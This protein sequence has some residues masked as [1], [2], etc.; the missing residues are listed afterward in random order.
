[1]LRV[2]IFVSIAA[3]FTCYSL[4]AVSADGP[5]RIIYANDMGADIDDAFALVF[6]LNSPELQI[7]CIINSFGR[8]PTKGKITAR[9]LEVAGRQDI[10]N[11]IGRVTEDRPQRFY[12]GMFRWVEGYEYT[13]PPVTDG[14]RA[15]ARRI[16]N[17]PG[18]VTVLSVGPLTDIA[19]LL[20][21]E[22]RVKDK[23]DEIIMMGGTID[24]GYPDRIE[25]NVGCDPNATQIVFASGLPIVMLG[26]DVTHM[27]QPDK[28]DMER[29]AA[30]DKPLARAVH[31]LF[32]AWGRHTPT[33][34]D[35]VAIAVAIER[36]IVTFEPMRI[37]VTDEGYTRKVEG[38]PNA[39]VGVDVDKDRFFKLF[40]E[41]VMK[42]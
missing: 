30:T 15:L 14:W 36:N 33:M 1:M 2:L 20:Q 6:A 35:A 25:H 26:F 41:R 17:A 40:W 16:L 42:N 27:M 38:E 13:K 12:G 32:L 5:R 39:L 37:H 34:Y 7:D 11:I 24:Y 4:S 10:P 29:L 18:T 28:E 19:D 22:P 23:I 8:T 9:L 31:E 3:V 21:N